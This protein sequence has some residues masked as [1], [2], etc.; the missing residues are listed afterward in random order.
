MRGSLWAKLTQFRFRAHRQL[1]AELTQLRY[2]HAGNSSA[3]RTGKRRNYEGGRQLCP[4]GMELRLR[5]AP[6]LFENAVAREVELLAPVDQSQRREP[7]P[8]IVSLHHDTLGV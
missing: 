3:G 2:A 1:W 6:M 8:A 5:R 4:G 7:V